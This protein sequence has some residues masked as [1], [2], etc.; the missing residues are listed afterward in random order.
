[1]S[2]QKRNGNPSR[3]VHPYRP[4]RCDMHQEQHS[5]YLLQ[6]TV[7]KSPLSQQNGNMKT[8]YLKMW[9]QKGVLAF[10][11]YIKELKISD[12]KNVLQINLYSGR[13]P[14][15]VSTSLLLI[16]LFAV[17]RVHSI[18]HTPPTTHV[19]NIVQREQKTCSMQA[20]SSF[21][22]KTHCVKAAIPHMNR[23]R[24]VSGYERKLL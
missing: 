2:W 11:F 16:A 23:Y 18:I 3:Q 17:V 15:L 4:C 6:P 24:L 14:K 20:I 1:M 9:L 19:K 22:F 5:S 12:K 8:S 21:L 13:Q 7:E 10:L